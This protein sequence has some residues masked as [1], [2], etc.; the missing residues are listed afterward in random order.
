MFNSNRNS[1]LHQ[2][3]LKI[4]TAKGRARVWVEGNY[5]AKAGFTAGSHFEAIE[6]KDSI[7]LILS[8]NAASSRTVSSR[9]SRTYPIIDYT[10]PEDC[11]L[12]SS[13]KVCVAVYQNAIVLRKERIDLRIAERRHTRT[14]VSLYAGGGLLTEAARQAGYECVAANEIDAG[15]AEVFA[16]NHPNATLLN[17]SIEQVNFDALKAQHGPIGLLDLGLPCEP[18]SNARRGKK[19]TNEN[20]PECHENGD[21]VFWALLAIDKLNPYSVILEEVPNFLNSAS[22]AILE[23]ALT[24]MGYFVDSKIF[25]ASEFGMATCRKRAVV[26]ATTGKGIAWPTPV[27]SSHLGA[28]LN[29]DNHPENE[30]FD[31]SSKS[32]LYDHW[33]NQTAKGNGF[34]PPVLDRSS[35]TVGTIKKRYFAQQGDN[36]VVANADRTKHRWFTI[37]EVKRITGLPETYEL[38][39]S[40]TRAGEI[41]GQGVPVSMFTEIIKSTCA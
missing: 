33:E 35:K 21:Q 15:Y 32:W 13:E 5:L 3:S 31:R 7:R 34:A 2:S 39:A 25:D 11:S 16:A 27:G 28:M 20:H 30:W 37:N 22:F 18:Y 41:M 6:G 8:K 12:S 26:C 19:G 38:G 9:K 1:I 10:L 14:S 40:K 29:H 4:G 24:R 17:C 23:R 36:P